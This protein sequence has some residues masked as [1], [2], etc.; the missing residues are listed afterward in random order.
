MSNF[1]G[2]LEALSTFIKSQKALLARTQSDIERLNTLRYEIAS[3]SAGMSTLDD[4]SKQV[5]VL[6]K[7]LGLGEY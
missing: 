7:V 5:S 6:N 4:F 2:R 3:T 1:H